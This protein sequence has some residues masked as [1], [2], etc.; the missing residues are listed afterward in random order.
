VA[1]CLL[2]TEIVLRSFLGHLGSIVGPQITDIIDT[3]VALAG[4]EI[5]HLATTHVFA[6]D[7]APVV[8][9]GINWTEGAAAASIIINYLVSSAYYVIV[10]RWR[11]VMTEAK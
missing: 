6:G 7:W 5:V 11:R 8:R 2:N 4:V 1:V 9:T 10:I 3:L